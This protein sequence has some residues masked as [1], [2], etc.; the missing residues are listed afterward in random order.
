[1]TLQKDLYAVKLVDEGKV[2]FF[3]FEQNGTVA[4]NLL[5]ELA[6]Y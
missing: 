4:A 6:D 5:S 1:M 2:G 3:Y